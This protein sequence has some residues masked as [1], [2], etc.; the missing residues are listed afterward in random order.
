MH[1][2]PGPSGLSCRSRKAHGL[3]RSEPTCHSVDVFPRSSGLAQPFSGPHSC[4]HQEA[5]GANLTV[6][7]ALRPLHA[8][9][10]EEAEATHGTASPVQ[11]V[12]RLLPLWEN[13]VDVNFALRQ[14]SFSGTEASL[15]PRMMFVCTFTRHRRHGILGLSDVAQVVWMVHAQRATLPPAVIGPALRSPEGTC[16][17]LPTGQFL[18]ATADPSLAHT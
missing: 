1:L 12:L 5:S 16:Q 3:E 13:F 2:L 4:R 11:A 10:D 9:H 6:V 18:A 14:N 17:S 7:P 8:P 15:G